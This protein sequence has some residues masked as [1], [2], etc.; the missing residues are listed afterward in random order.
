MFTK[1]PSEKSALFIHYLTLDEVPLHAFIFST[2]NEDGNSLRKL[3][4]DI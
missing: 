2:V 4:E 1:L 3:H